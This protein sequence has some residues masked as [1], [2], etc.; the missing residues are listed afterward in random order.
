MMKKYLVHYD[1]VESLFKDPEKKQLEMERFQD[2][3]HENVLLRSYI[4]KDHKDIW[5]YF[6]VEDQFTL[7]EI[8]KTLPSCS[9]LKPDFH[10]LDE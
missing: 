3:M 10:E 6:Q 9:H 1:R 2:L 4:S 8:L 7:S 5:L